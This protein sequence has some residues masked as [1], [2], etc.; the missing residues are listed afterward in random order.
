[1]SPLSETFPLSQQKPDLSKVF[2]IS[3]GIT[4][5]KMHDV[6]FSIFETETSVSARGRGSGLTIHWALDTSLSLLLH[7]IVDRLTGTEIDPEASKEGENGNFVF[8]DLRSGEAEM[9][10]SP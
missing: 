8:F 10:C 1:M 5:L 7:R 2:I 9:K 6:A 4:G 3:A